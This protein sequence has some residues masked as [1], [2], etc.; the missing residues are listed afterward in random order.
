MYVIGL[1]FQKA[2]CK[3]NDQIIAIGSENQGAMGATGPSGVQGISGDSG[4]IGP[5]GAEGPMG[6]TGFTGEAGQN[7]VSGHEI[8][9]ISD[10]STTDPKILTATCPDGKVVTGGGYSSSTQSIQIQQN[11]PSAI[12]AWTVDVNKTTTSGIWTVTV[13]AVCVAV[14]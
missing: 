10:A 1:G 4:P 3:R 6:A 8:V 12:N 13:Y 5:T 9:T 11:N 7:G 2:D 14:N